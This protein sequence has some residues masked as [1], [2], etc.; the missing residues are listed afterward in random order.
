MPS[1]EYKPQFMQDGTWC[2]CKEIVTELKRAEDIVRMWNSYGPYL[3]E[4][5]RIIKWEIIYAS[6]PSEL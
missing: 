5:T 4:A 6:N 3:V 2:E 1:I